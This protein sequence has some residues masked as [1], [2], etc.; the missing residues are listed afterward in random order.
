MLSVREACMCVCGGGGVA[1]RGFKMGG[2]RLVG[3][4]A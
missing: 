2:V 3:L 1:A 4:A